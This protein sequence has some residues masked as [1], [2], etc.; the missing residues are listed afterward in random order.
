MVCL[1]LSSSSAS[2]SASSS[3]LIPPPS[4]GQLYF[5]LFLSLSLFSFSHLLPFFLFS[6]FLFVFFLINLFFVSA[7]P[8]P[9][10]RYSTTN[11]T[12]FRCPRFSD[13]FLFYFILSSLVHR[14]LRLP[15]VIHLPSVPPSPARFC[16]HR[17]PP[18]YRPLR[19]S[20]PCPRIVGFFSIAPVSLPTSIGCLPAVTHFCILCFC[21]CALPDI[22]PFAP[23]ISIALSWP[24]TGAENISSAPLYRASQPFI[25]GSDIP[26]SSSLPFPPLLP[27]LALVLSPSRSH[28]FTNLHTIF[29]PFIFLRFA[30]LDIHSHRPCHPFTQTPLSPFRARCNRRS[31]PPL[32]LSISFVLIFS[33]DRCLLSPLTVVDSLFLVPDPPN[34]ISLS[35][36]LSLSPQFSS[37]ACLLFQTLYV[38]PLRMVNHITLPSLHH[39]SY[40]SLP[41]LL[42]SLLLSTPYFIFAFVSFPSSPT[43]V[44]LRLATDF[45]GQERLIYC[46]PRQTAVRP[47]L[48]IPPF[49]ILMHLLRHNG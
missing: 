49:R 29:C 11:L 1:S 39:T 18:D 19:R 4:S 36:S 28:G 40:I 9:D 24:A 3:P 38:R 41:R 21:C 42:F 43:F 10:S 5:W 35:P 45:S 6:F 12:V 13:S 46:K 44:P 17:P 27:G 16:R 31:I 34:S 26:S 32:T 15:A 22:S 8:V 20:R 23:F 48:P 47:P 2:S 37:L 25:W 14:P 33:T 7:P 30:S